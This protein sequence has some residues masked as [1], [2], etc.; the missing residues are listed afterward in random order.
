M[1][2]FSVSIFNM[3]RE[4]S[5][6]PGWD[7]LIGLFGMF[8]FFGT[9]GV[10][11]ALSPL[12]HWLL[13]GTPDYVDIVKI[14]LWTAIKTS[15][16]YF[17][18]MFLGLFLATFGIEEGYGISRVINIIEKTFISIKKFL[19]SRKVIRVIF[20]SLSVIFWII[21]ALTFFSIGYGGSFLK[22]ITQHCFDTLLSFVMITVSTNMMFFAALLKDDILF[23]KLW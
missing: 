8:L 12:G 2:M 18:L 10:C 20:F 13:Q 1:G 23:K 19:K 14:T 6:Y 16:F 7:F 3:F 11:L 15:W 4:D 9:F 21:S 17:V 22:D 5:K